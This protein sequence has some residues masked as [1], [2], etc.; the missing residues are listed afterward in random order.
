MNSIWSLPFALTFMTTL[1][2]SFTIVPLLAC[3]S[4]SFVVAIMSRK[5]VVN[6]L[7]TVPPATAVLI[8]GTS[9]GI[10][11]DAVLRLA[12]AGF[13]VFATVRKQAD[14]DRL[15]L[16]AKTN[17]LIKDDA[18]KPLILDVTNESQLKAAVT[19]VKTVLS[20]EGKQLYGIV[21][22]AGMAE[23]GPMELI[24]LSALKYQFDANVFGVIAVTQAF[25]PLLR[26]CAIPGYKPRVVIVSSVVGH[27]SMAGNSAYCASKHA[28]EA[29]GDGLRQ[30][31]KKFNIVVSLV[32]PGAI[33][34]S[35]GKT[36]MAGTDKNVDV[37][38]GVSTSVS[39]DV[40]SSYRASMDKMVKFM[41]NVKTGTV[42]IVS[43]TIVSALLDSQPLPR[44]LSGELNCTST[45][46]INDFIGSVFCACFISMAF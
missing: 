31:L 26:Q 24:P 28:I 10:G 6:K 17:T 44:Y 25:L 2:L 12:A 46:C 15:K 14:A 38:E 21:N 7:Q 23:P 36:L 32:K 37:A 13:T 22:N 8:T 29:L 33:D 4:F 11:F 40:R 45:A 30:E 16:A 42:S 18:I 20:T 19:Q 34:T 3:L 9:S 43:D 39:R 41:S 27:V 35:F 1:F 5:F